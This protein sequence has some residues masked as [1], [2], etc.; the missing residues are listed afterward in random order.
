VIELTTATAAHWREASH[1]EE[2]GGGVSNTV[3]LAASAVLKQA[4]AKLRVE[5]EWL[6]DRARIFREA[7]AM[8]WAQGRV[9]GGR[10]PKILLEDRENF[11]IAMEAAPPDARTW[12]ELLFDGVLDPSTARAAGTMLGSLIA[13]SWGDEEARR[14][15]GDQIVFDQLRIDPYF[16]ATAA[17][18]PECAEYLERLMER[19][20]GRRVS[21]V[22]GDWS[23]KNLLVGGG[24]VWA[25]DWEV[26]H[27]G[28]PSFDVAFL[29]NHLVLKSIAM[30]GRRDAL[31]T[32]AGEFVEALRVELPPAAQW[33]E[34]AAL[35]HLP[36]LLLA[37]VEGKSPTEYL[38]EAGR[39]WTRRLAIGMMREPVTSVTK[40]FAR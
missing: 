16:R 12:K 23:P 17:A 30:P 33:I 36:A 4:L 13:A 2:L 10:V 9:R 22:H 31:T 28:D 21:L 11:V 25:I 14:D 6:S 15:F 32:L 34:E 37:R 38:D 35:E 39:G 40:V 5:R 7:A 20:A 1:F 18:V 27:F 8:R 24:E 3:I 29:L 19:T 26:V